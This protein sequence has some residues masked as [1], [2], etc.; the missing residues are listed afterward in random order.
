MLDKTKEFFNALKDIDGG[1]LIYGFKDSVPSE[2]IVTSDDI[3]TNINRFKSF[4]SGANPTYKEGYVWSTIWLGHSEEN[5]N[6]L[7]GFKY[8]CTEHDTNLYRKKLQEK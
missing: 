8:W 4:F 3:P 6:L 1:A 7:A 5:A 2:A